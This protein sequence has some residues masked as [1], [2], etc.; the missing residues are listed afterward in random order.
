LPNNVRYTTIVEPKFTEE[1]IQ[2][3]G[4]MIVITT[5]VGKLAGTLEHVFIDHV[6]LAVH[7]K[8]HHI[9]DFPHQLY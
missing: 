7:G 1:L 9:P 4:L 3:I 5:V 8:K 6:A 2:H